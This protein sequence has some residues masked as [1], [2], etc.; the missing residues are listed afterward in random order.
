MMSLYDMYFSKL[1]KNH[2][3]NTLSE[4]LIKETGFDIKNDP[5]YIDLYRLYY[6]SIFD[7]IDTD[8]LSILNREIINQIGSLFLEKLKQPEIINPKNISN[9]KSEFIKPITKKIKNIYSIQRDKK[10]KNRFDFKIKIDVN[11]FIIKNI[12]LLKEKN[13]LFSND[14]IFIQVNEKDNIAFKYKDKSKIGNDEY[15][16]YECFSDNIIKADSKDMIHIKILNY[17][18]MCPSD[19]KDIFKIEKHKQVKYEKDTYTCLKINNHDFKVDQEL[20]FLTKDHKLVGTNFINYIFDEYVLIEKMD[21]KDIK[22]CLKM[23]QNISIQIL[24]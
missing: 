10:S 24:V 18:M 2:M 20:G 21:L 16:N 6:P 23:N 9:E 5:T 1:N 14:T 19:K 4:L 11:D 8:E 22:Y 3:F 13:S 15:Y 17:L 7:K 12:T